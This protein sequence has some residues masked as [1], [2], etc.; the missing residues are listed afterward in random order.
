MA[1]NIH[2]KAKAMADLLLGEAP[3]AVSAQL[4]IPARTV[5]RWRCE[6]WQLVQIAPEVRVT[7]PAPADDPMH[8]GQT[9]GART[10]SG[11]PCQNLPVRG[12]VRC[13]MHGGR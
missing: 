12:K 11:E 4:G 3:N 5:R 13:R 6:A 10:R 9:C 2:I 7:W 8:S 1:H